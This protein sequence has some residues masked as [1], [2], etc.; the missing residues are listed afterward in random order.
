MSKIFCDVGEV[1]K[2]KK[3]GSMKECA[4]LGKVKYWGEKKVDKKIIESVVDKKKK[5][6]KNMEKELDSMKIKFAGMKGKIKRLTREIETEKD[7]KEM[8]KKLTE[9]TH[10][11]KEL[12][13]LQ[14]KMVTLKEKIEK[15][16]EKEKKSKKNSKKQSRVKKS[17]KKKSSKKKSS[18]KK[19]SKK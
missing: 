15:E 19:S 10:L 18:K 11:E 13:N 14:E 4:E 17:S 12:K 2:G 3:R 7:K 8:K 5:G 6:S 1:P 9:K 16:K